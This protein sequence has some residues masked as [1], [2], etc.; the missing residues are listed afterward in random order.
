MMHETRPTNPHPE[1]SLP[2]FAGVLLFL[3]ASCFFSF[4]FVGSRASVA[5]PALASA[6]FP[7][8]ASSSFAV[9]DFDGDS[10]PDTATVQASQGLSA[11]T[12]DYL[13]RLRLSAAGKSYIR[14]TAPKGGLRVE[15]RDVNG[16]N[17]PDIVLATTWHDRPVAVL[18][19]DGHGNF[20]RV[21]PS[22]YRKL[23]SQANFG[24]RNVPSHDWSTAGMPQDPRPGF[25]RTRLV[26]QSIQTQQGMAGLARSMLPPSSLLALPA[27]RAPPASA[28]L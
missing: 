7:I 16:D 1:C 19:N 4:H 21:D 26:S 20:S 11:S 3:F 15:A 14:L 9:A 6:A 5:R 28:L 27:G 22:A 17:A 23:F 12:E 8:Q 25:F 13:V 2:Y 10:K 24:F 18:L